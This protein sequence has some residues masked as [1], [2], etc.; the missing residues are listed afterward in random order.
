MVETVSRDGLPI[1]LC[2]RDRPSRYYLKT[3]FGPVRQ[4]KA[5][6]VV[7]IYARGRRIA[8]IDF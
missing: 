6:R 2:V 4:R 1:L 8:R 5:M 7:E 3:I